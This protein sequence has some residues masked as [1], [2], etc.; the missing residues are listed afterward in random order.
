MDYLQRSALGIDKPSLLRHVSV[1]KFLVLRADFDNCTNNKDRSEG[2]E[3]W[4]KD[5][6]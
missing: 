3:E 4:S 2:E 1:R 6:L 5:H